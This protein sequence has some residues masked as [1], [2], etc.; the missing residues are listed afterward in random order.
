MTQRVLAG[1]NARRLTAVSAHGAPL[2]LLSRAVGAILSLRALELAARHVDYHARTTLLFD[3]WGASWLPKPGPSGALAL[4][5]VSALSGLA[6]SL[7]QG[8]A[9]LLALL[10]ALLSFGYFFALDKAFYGN[11]NLALLMMLLALLSA[12]CWRARP[13]PNSTTPLGLATPRVL[14]ASIYFY[15]GLVKLDPDW[16]GGGTL[17]AFFGAPP[18]PS[19]GLVA[20][21]W[22]GAAFDLL[23]G[24]LLLWPRTRKGAIA[25]ALGFHAVNFIALDVA[26]VALSFAALTLAAFLPERRAA[27]W[28]ELVPCWPADDAWGRSRSTSPEPLWAVLSAAFLATALLVPL[29]PYIEA[30]GQSSR[31]THHAQDFSWWL[32]STHVKAEVEFWLVVDDQA[33]EKIDVARYIDVK[34]QGN[35]ALDPYLV[36]QF[37][38]HVAADVARDR[39]E[40][41]RVSVYVTSSAQLSAR[42][43]QPLYREEVDFVAAPLRYDMTELVVPLR[44]VSSSSDVSL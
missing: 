18:P 27:R 35:F 32:R 16:L 30:Q 1:L 11:L 2:V 37:A 24:P 3:Y 17:A 5:L 7:T 43:P 22:L 13:A 14:L 29:R 15:A 41:E 23:I 19:P 44:P 20:M 33:R 4:L 40:A 8:R 34:A 25:L 6:I 12:Q 10:L 9:Q 21:S 38:R 28:L 31:W 36:A 39:P 26:S 42:A